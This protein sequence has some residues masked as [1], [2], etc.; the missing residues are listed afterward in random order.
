MLTRTQA[1]RAAEEA[2]AAATP[3]GKRS[4]L[5]E[6]ITSSII[7]TRSGAGG[8]GR[9][10][11]R[12]GR[13]RKPYSSP[14]SKVVAPKTYISSESLSAMSSA[15]TSEESSGDDEDMV[16][17]PDSSFEL[18]VTAGPIPIT[19]QRNHGPPTTPPRL[20]PRKLQRSPRAQRWIHNGSIITRIIYSEE[21][22]EEAQL[23]SIRDERG[24]RNI[25]ERELERLLRERMFKKVVD[26]TLFNLHVD[27]TNTF[28]SKPRFIWSATGIQSSY[29]IQVSRLNDE[30]YDSVIWDSGE[31]SS[32]ESLAEYAG[33]YL[34]PRTRYLWTLNVELSSGLSVVES[35]AFTTGHHDHRFHV[36][37]LNHGLKR[38][39]AT[40]TT[41]LAPL[42]LAFK[43]STWI[44]TADGAAPLFLA[45]AGDRFF[46]RT[47]TPPTGKSATLAEIIIA[48]DNKYSLFVNG[49]LAGVSPS[50]ADSWESAQGYTMALSPGP[51]VFAVAGTNAAGSG[52]GG[53][54]AAGLVAAI[55]ITHSDGTQVIINTDKQWLASSVAVVSFQSPSLD[56]STWVAA[57]ELVKFGLGPWALTVTLPST[58]VTVNLPVATTSSTSSLSTSS[59]ISTTSTLLSTSTTTPLTT[60]SIVPIA[61]SS[62]ITVTSIASTDAAVAPTTST[63]S[64][65]KKSGTNPA[66]IGGAL[67]G[68]VGGFAILGLVL[69]FWRQRKRDQ[70][71]STDADTWV[72]VT[73]AASAPSVNGS[74]HNVPLMAQ[75]QGINRGATDS[76]TPHRPPRYTGTTL[77][78]QS[79]PTNRYLPP[80]AAMTPDA[81]GTGYSSQYTTSNS[82]TTLPYATPASNNSYGANGFSPTQVY[83][84]NGYNTT[85]AYGTNGYGTTQD[86]GNYGTRIQNNQPNVPYSLQ[87]AVSQQQ[88]PAYPGQTTYHNR[89]HY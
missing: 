46:R 42:D 15:T 34:L 87:P 26:P 68:V 11:G 44:W 5:S 62:T 67:G 1:K 18:P 28:V 2:A 74:T 31:I 7:R 65:T 53:A 6:D 81:G 66:I 37:T 73:H 70:V 27:Q 63:T 57:T 12:G 40:T 56:D 86:Y 38:R 72:P 8:G 23:R 39:Q 20:S 82:P 85:Q 58:L 71:D 25:A 88:Q 80:S 14:R 47:Y 35:S 89:R 24:F 4:R 61:S 41:N 36:S 10:R 59:T 19:P 69:I 22:A 84:T 16:V 9:G 78:I 76:P 48:V 45:Q 51:V 29:H 43:T 17:T 50:N 60:S 55:R 77:N 49:A 30:S 64:E 13:P 32:S 33:P 75:A 54:N 52:K 79:P 21:S 3:K 83:G